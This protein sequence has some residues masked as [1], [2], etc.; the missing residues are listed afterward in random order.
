MSNK[1]NNI[2][3]VTT[4]RKAHHDFFIEEEYEAGLELKGSEVKSLRVHGCSIQEAYAKNI[5]DQIFII[6][7]YITPYEKSSVDRLEPDRT[8]K[9][10]MHRSEIDK[11]IAHCTQRGYTLIPLKIYFRKGWAKV[12]IGL[13]RKRKKGDKRRKKLEKQ[14]KREINQ[15]LRRFKRKG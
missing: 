10:L 6:G 5:G 14:Q 7:M 15:E 4:N 12:K 13:A 3:I 1:D 2:K 8:R 9:L 11:L